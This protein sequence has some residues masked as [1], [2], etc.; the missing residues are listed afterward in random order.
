MEILRTAQ[1]LFFLDYFRSVV[2]YSEIYWKS[3]GNKKRTSIE[4]VS[5]GVVFDL[6]INYCKTFL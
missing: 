5:D 2:K 6:S 1:V 4:I 3:M